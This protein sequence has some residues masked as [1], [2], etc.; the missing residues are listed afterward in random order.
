MS[1]EEIRK[2]LYLLKKK[3]LTRK[4]LI[5]LGYENYDIDHLKAKRLIYIMDEKKRGK[6]ADPNSD[7][8]IVNDEGHNSLEAF[9]MKKEP[10]DIAK[11]SL[12]LS[13]IAIV[14]SVIAIIVSIAIGLYNQSK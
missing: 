2:L 7:T 14:L 4:E 9:Y 6:Y 12:K 8:F 1:D 10:I 11:K 5:D 3:P 13:K